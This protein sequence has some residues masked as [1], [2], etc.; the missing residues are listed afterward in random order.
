MTPTLGFLI[1]LAVSCSYFAGRA[2]ERY[3]NSIYG[4]RAIKDAL[5]WWYRKPEFR[6]IH[7]DQDCIGHLPPLNIWAP[8]KRMPCWVDRQYEFRRWCAPK[9]RMA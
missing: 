1:V 5:G 6:E 7:C 8:Q 4:E 9:L 3:L 2:H